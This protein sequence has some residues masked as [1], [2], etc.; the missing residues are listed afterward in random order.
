MSELN[1]NEVV[2][3]VVEVQEEQDPY[4][5]KL[6]EFQYD[7]PFTFSLK[8]VPYAKSAF[9]IIV[10]ILFAIG[11]KGLGGIALGLAIATPGLINIIA[12]KN[13]RLI[14]LNDEIIVVYDLT[15]PEYIQRFTWDDIVTYGFEE[16]P[17]GT[18][19]IIRLKDEYSAVVISGSGKLMDQF[20]KRIPDKEQLQLFKITRAQQKKMLSFNLFKKKK[21]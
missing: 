4:T 11:V 7:K 19:F 9:F 15:D 5:I 8:L 21:K 16:G 12:V 1:T 17:H 18:M 14:E 2:E 3:E 6:K 20:Q 10:A 13:K